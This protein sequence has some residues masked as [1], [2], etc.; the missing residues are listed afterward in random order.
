MLGK[1]LAAT[2]LASS[3]NEG[4]SSLNSAN[5]SPEGATPQGVAALGDGQVSISLSD[6]AQNLLGEDGSTDGFQALQNLLGQDPEKAFSGFLGQ[7]LDKFAGGLSQL[8]S[9]VFSLPIEDALVAARE[10]TAGLRQAL[11]GRG[12]LQAQFVSVVQSQASVAGANG[13]AGEASLQLRSVSIAFDDDA[14]AFKLSVEEVSVSHREAV[15]LADGQALEAAGLSPDAAIAAAQSETTIAIKSFEYVRLEEQPVRDAPPPIDAQPS[16][17]ALPAFGGI[18]PAANFALVDDNALLPV[19]ASLLRE[20][21][22]LPAVDDGSSSPPPAPVSGPEL[23]AVDARSLEDVG[24]LIPGNL[25]KAINENILSVS[26]VSFDVSVQQS[27]AVAITAGSG[28]GAQTPAPNGG[29]VDVQ[30]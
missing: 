20:L 19:P 7:A 12:D 14:N 24:L 16:A 21:L 18:E 2:S 11:D 29:G 9:S 6:L 13:Q 3:L 4:R 23:N 17:F 30:A 10:A 8:T 15:A 25:W 1:L 28:A 5:G 22:S 27:V 26:R